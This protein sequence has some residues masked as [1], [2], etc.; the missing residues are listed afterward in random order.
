MKRI[1]F[2]SEDY[3]KVNRKKAMIKIKTCLSDGIY[4]SHGG[5]ET[6][7]HYAW[8]LG[9]RNLLKAIKTLADH[10]EH[11]ENCYGSG[12]C[13]ASWIEIAGVELGWQDIESIN[14]AYDRTEW[15]HAHGWGQTPTQVATELINSLYNGQLAAD[16]RQSLID[17]EK[18]DERLYA[19]A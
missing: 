5:G 15:E 13:G 4:R 16:R 3:P 19:C 7:V 2:D 12:G 17:E 11:M 18:E 6:I 1:K 14:D 8:K 9:P 10:A